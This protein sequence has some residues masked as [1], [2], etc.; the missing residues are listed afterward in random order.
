MV[1]D[2]EAS[3]IACQAE[4]SDR[5]LDLEGIV[6]V[7]APDGFGSYFLAP[8]LA[9][10]CNNSPKLRINLI[11]TAR[12]FSQAQGEIDI[13]ISLAMPK[14]GRIVGRKLVDNDRPRPGTPYPARRFRAPA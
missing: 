14:E 2:V 6:R 9:A 10:F 5:N 8:G 4:I 1:E 12:V 7:G 13:A 3:I 11:A